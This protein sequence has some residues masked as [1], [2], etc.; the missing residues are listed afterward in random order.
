MRISISPS[1]KQTYSTPQ[2]NHIIH[3]PIF[4]F[5]YYPEPTYFI[6]SA[7]LAIIP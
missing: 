4:H 7:S 1:M 2:A 3:V 5:T 6:C